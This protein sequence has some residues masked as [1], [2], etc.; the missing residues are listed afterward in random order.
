[1][2]RKLVQD[3]AQIWNDDRETCFDNIDEIAEFFAGNR[4][5]GKSHADKDFTSKQY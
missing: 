5:W 3:K 2:I 4:D 1:M